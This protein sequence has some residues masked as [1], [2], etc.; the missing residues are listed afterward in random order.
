MTSK[1]GATRRAFVGGI[2]AAS[3]TPVA[4]LGQQQRAATGTP[5]SVI[6]NPPRQWGRH[7]QPDIYPD[8]DI[9]IVDP[10]FE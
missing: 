4:A 10:V 7:A 2:A 5:P 8:P 3:V 9:I 6:S 1:T